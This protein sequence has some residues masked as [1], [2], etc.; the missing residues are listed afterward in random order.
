[1]TKE[2][3]FYYDIVSPYTYLAYKRIIEIENTS[4]IKYFQQGR[5]THI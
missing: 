2:I 1:M 5:V 3:E 4:N